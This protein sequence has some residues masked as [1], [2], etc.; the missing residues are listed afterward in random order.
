LA[1]QCIASKV[2]CTKEAIESAVRNIEKAS[3]DVFRLIDEM[4]IEKQAQNKKP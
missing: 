3:M 1:E 2:S 4:T